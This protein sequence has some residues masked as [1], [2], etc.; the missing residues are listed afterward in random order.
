VPY[1]ETSLRRS[2]AEALGQ[3]RRAGA[4]LRANMRGA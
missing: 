3:L 2:W 4:P 1:H